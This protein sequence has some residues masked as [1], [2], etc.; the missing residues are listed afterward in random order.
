MRS[1]VFIL[2]NGASWKPTTVPRIHA[3]VHEGSNS[4]AVAP[5]RFNS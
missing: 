2:F 5:A 1:L 4:Q 3:A